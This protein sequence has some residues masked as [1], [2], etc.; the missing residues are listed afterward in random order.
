[1]ALKHT[2]QK[3]L[4]R[5][6]Q[7]RY[8]RAYDRA[9]A[10]SQNRP[11][12]VLFT[13][14]ARAQMGGNMA[15]VYECMKERGLANTC[16]IDFDL[17]ASLPKASD[18]AYLD[19][20]V[21]KA[22]AADVIFTDDNHPYLNLITFRREVKVVQLWHAVGAFKTVGFSRKRENAESYAKA[23]FAHRCYTHVIVS[24][25]CDRPHYAQAFRQ[26]VERVHAT[27]I[28]RIDGFLDPAFQEQ[29]KRAFFERFECAR[30][31]RVVLF[32]PTFR[33]DDIRT[34]GY[35]FSRID[36]AALAQWCRANDTVFIQ[37]LHPYIH[38]APELASDTADIILDA[39][40]IREVNEILPA[41][42]VV[43]TDYSSVIYEASLLLKPLV[44]FVYDLEEYEASRGFYE[45]FDEYACGPIVRDF[46]A[47]LDA[48]SQ[49]PDLE[50][51]QRFRDKHFAYVDQGS[52]G[53]VVDLVFA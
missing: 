48:L 35:D 27:G 22:A 49:E 39:S 20:F 8:D 42:D 16:A 5:A 51:V 17:R 9:R 24:A 19:A 50:P 1:M 32:A 11:T 33:G 3:L 14:V 10:G 44:F 31:K 34:S 29:S 45:P 28:P 43:V 46:P 21:D 25:E 41:A 23:S 40:D 38:N 6:L 30:G 37:K 12:H 26:P 52:S 4:A 36:Y 18:K 13:S 15:F 2:A 47:L 7:K 53:R